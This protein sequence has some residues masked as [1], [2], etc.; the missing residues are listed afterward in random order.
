MY[1]IKKET[2]NIKNLFLQLLMLPF[3]T[4]HYTLFT[5]TLLLCIRDRENIWIKRHNTQARCE[6][7]MSSEKTS[8]FLLIPRII[9]VIILIY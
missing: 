8:T 4:L 5:V 3:I 6:P 1:P 9:I 2:W 7:K